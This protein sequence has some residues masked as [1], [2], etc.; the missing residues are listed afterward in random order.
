MKQC[1]KCSKYFKLVGFATYVDR[2]GVRRRRGVCSTCRFAYQQRNFDQLQA[3]RKEYNARTKTK[4]QLRN[5]SY[6]EAAKK[7]VDDY[8]RRPC[9]DCGKKFPPVAMDL[10][11]VRG[12]KGRN[13]SSM[14]SGAYCLDLI[15]GELEKCEVVCA[16]CHRI[17]THSKKENVGH[18]RKTTGKKTGG[19]S[20]SGSYLKFSK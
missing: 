9:A 15:K 5:R 18:I 6:R 14:V 1:G 13:V 12:A 3:W 19:K 11:H 4:R 2:Q 7:Y 20:G 17:R 10:D 16:C 8:K